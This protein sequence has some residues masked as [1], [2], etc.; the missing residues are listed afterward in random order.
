M[1]GMGKREVERDGRAHHG[2]ADD[3]GAR[4]LQARR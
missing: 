2:T 1:E 3:G 4:L